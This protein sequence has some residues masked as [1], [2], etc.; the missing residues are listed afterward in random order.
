MSR[1][2]VDV[3]MDGASFDSHTCCICTYLFQPKTSFEVYVDKN[4]SDAWPWV[5]VNDN[6]QDSEQ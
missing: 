1:N 6:G 4:A 3:G 5:D 2:E